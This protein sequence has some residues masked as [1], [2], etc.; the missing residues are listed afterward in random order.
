M[1]T[2]SQTSGSAPGPSLLLSV[3]SP[4]LKIAA[5]VQYS[6]PPATFSPLPDHFCPP[7]LS[8]SL[9]PCSLSL[10]VPHLG[11][12]AWVLRVPEEHVAHRGV[13]VRQVLVVDRPGW[14]QHNPQVKRITK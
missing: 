7:S 5:Y 11:H 3:P 2:I 12:L 4:R 8:L 14:D 1:M 13:Q 9:L 10:P 6:G